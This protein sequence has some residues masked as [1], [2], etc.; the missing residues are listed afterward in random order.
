MPVTDRLRRTALIVWASVGGLV[1]AWA[2]LKIAGA[3]RIIWLPLA[4]ATGLVVLLDPLVRGLQRIAIPRVLGTIFAYIAMAALL[5][6]VGFL[7]VP[8][9]RDQATDFGAGLPELYDSVVQWLKETSDRIGIDLGPVWTSETIQEWIADPTNQESIQSVLGGFGS[10]AGRVLAGVVETVAVVVLAPVLGFY[11]LVDL[12]RTR[13]IALNLVPPRI[14]DEVG[15]VARQVGT[16]LAAFVRGQLLVALVVGTLSAI[17][18]WILDLPFWL[19]IGMAAGLL[20]MVPFAGPFF[21]AALAVI[22]ALVDGSFTKAVLAVVIFTAIQQVD[23]QLITPLVQRTRVRLSP[24]VIVLAL[25]AGGSAAGLLGV[26][27][28]VPTVSVLRIVVGH[29]WRTRVL[30][31]SWAD[32]SEAMMEVTQRPEVLRPMR[33]RDTQPKLFDTGEFVPMAPDEPAPEPGTRVGSDS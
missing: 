11:L 10:G 29:I 25:L 1:L 13:R 30:G 23:N 6:A 2:A 14:R 17:G 27:I 9:V 28:A 5:V 19:I 32:A 26:L 7:V 8:T 15:F 3:V 12:P 33:K 16:A 20:N 22:V 4:F 24:V 31:E 21:G 18:L